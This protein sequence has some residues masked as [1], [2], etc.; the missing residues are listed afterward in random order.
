MKTE[1]DFFDY[2]KVN[3]KIKSK[4]DK[5]NY[6]VL[7][8][9]YLS[10]LKTAY[11][12]NNRVFCDWYEPK[13]PSDRAVVIL[14]GWRLSRTKGTERFCNTLVRQGFHALLPTFPYH[15][16]RTPKGTISGTY[17]FS[18]EEQRSVEA[19]RQAIIDLRALAD[20]LEAR[21]L[22]FG[23]MGTSLGAI[24]LHTLMGVEPRYRVGVSIL[25]SGHIH[26]IVWDGLFGRHIVRHLK[27]KG[28]S[29]RDY[30]HILNDYAKFLEKVEKTHSIPEAGQSW[31]KIDPL[32][33]AWCNQPRKVLFIN[34]HYD[35]IIPRQAVEETLVRLGGPPV[36]WLPLTHFT[37]FL[38]NPYIKRKALAFL[39]QNLTT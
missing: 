34:S 37:I 30:R 35:P 17:F 27:S 23:V 25:G 19:F 26:R 7:E 38:F 15:G 16:K 1:I 32:T 21:G 10:P 28:M 22:R 14:H 13:E 36:I 31:Y 9:E 3:F 39:K 20:F 18:K 11:P 33:Y 29:R 6:R 2:S 8:I 4:L 5:P 12:E 24:V